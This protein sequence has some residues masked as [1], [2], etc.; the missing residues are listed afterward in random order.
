VS[1][2]SSQ[3]D[4]SAYRTGTLPSGESLAH[5][6]GPALTRRALELAHLQPG[7]RILDVGCGSGHSMHLL[8]SHGFQALGV[9]PAAGPWDFPCIRAHAESLPLPDASFAAVLLECSLS[10]MDRPQQVLSECAR[11]LVNGGRLIVSDLYARAPGSLHQ[12]RALGHSCISGMIVREEVES[13]LANVGF[14]LDLW[15]DH[16]P[17]LREFVARFLLGGGSLPELW[18]CGASSDDAEAV[19]QAM[20]SVRAG[21]FLLIATRVP[22]E[23]R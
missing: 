8:A 11:V 17:E 3:A 18:G 21:Y 1:C 16:S 10:I 15:E 12:V 6:G 20:R 5:P 23:S 7:A 4:H 2:C 14:S 22:G 13:W 9:D 19:V